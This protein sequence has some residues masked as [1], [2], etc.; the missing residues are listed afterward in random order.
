MTWVIPI[1]LAAVLVLA[2]IQCWPAAPR[3][4]SWLR[5]QAL[6]ALAWLGAGWM[7]T[8]CWPLAVVL[9]ITL[10]RAADT[11]DDGVRVWGMACLL[12]AATL[13]VPPD[14]RPLLLGTYVATA[15]G[16]CG[17]L[18]WQ[19]VR[20]W[21][22]SRRMPISY[23]DVRNALH[24]SMGTRFFCGLL[25]AQA[26]PF[27]PGWLLPWLGAGLVATASATA[28]LAA[29]VGL[30]LTYPAQALVILPA[31]AIVGGLGLGFRKGWVPVGLDVFDDGLRERGRI[32]RC[33]G[34]R[35]MRL[36]WSARLLGHGHRGFSKQARWW[37]RKDGPTRQVH[38]HANHDA[39]QAL[40]EIGLLGVAALAWL[41]VTLFWQHGR[42]GDPLTGALAAV[43]IGSCI[44]FP[45]HAA[46]MALPAL[47]L[48]ALLATA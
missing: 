14:W 44:Q 34:A 35:W 4:S 47:I 21:R 39:A 18:G 17:L 6:L 25:I 16:Q 9:A 32:L 43:L 27:A 1:A 15:A 19:G 33:I 11:R 3:W 8:V 46:H 48:A 10:W 29:T 12:W 26:M 2:S 22:L 5:E 28:V 31:M 24:G 40:L 38:V 37:G 30:W 23:H 20:I 41:V 42:F 7:A 13:Q 36:D 45:L